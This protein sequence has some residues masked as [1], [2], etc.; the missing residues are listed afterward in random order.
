MNMKRARRTTCH[1]LLGWAAL[2]LISASGC[3]SGQSTLTEGEF[4]TSRIE[5]GNVETYVLTEGT[6]EPANEV[7]L[8]S[9][10]SSIIQKY[11]KNPASGSPK[12]KSSF[13]WIREKYNPVLKS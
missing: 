11:I 9:P 1:G 13:S 10:A 5:R 2:L 7:I 4:E 3:H 12:G 6:I 8:L